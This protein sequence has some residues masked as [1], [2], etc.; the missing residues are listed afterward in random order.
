[1]INI[2]VYWTVNW[3]VSYLR[4]DGLDG[5]GKGLPVLELVGDQAHEAGEILFPVE[6]RSGP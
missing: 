5:G 4:K 3:T 2:L 1:M 6:G